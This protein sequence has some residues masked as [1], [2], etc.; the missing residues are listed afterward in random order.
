MTTLWRRVA[1]FLGAPLVVGVLLLIF[2]SVDV[3]T[4]YG[5]STSTGLALV[6]AIP[7]PVWTAGAGAAGVA[8]LVVLARVVQAR[9]QPRNW[10]IVAAGWAPLYG[11]RRFEKD[12]AGVVWRLRLPIRTALQNPD[13]D[14]LRVDVP[15][16][17]PRCKTELEER[18]HLLGGY[19]WSCADVE[20]RFRLRSRAPI[21]AVADQVGKVARRDLEQ[22]MTAG[23]GRTG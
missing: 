4:L 20:C 2:R 14:H 10:P 3:R 19:T 6:R 7:L 13:P 8:V 17:C 22:A 15:P 9:R 11:W 21:L 18:P 16:R 5:W 1:A 12:Y 23:T